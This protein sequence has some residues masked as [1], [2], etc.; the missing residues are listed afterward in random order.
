M[1][2]TDSEGEPKGSHRLPR[3]AADIH[4]AFDRGTLSRHLA[5]FYRD[6]ETQL[7]TAA[8]YIAVGLR[9]GHRCLYLVD[10]TTRDCIERALRTVGVDVDARLECGDLLIAEAEEVYLDSG[11][12]PERMIATLREACTESVTDGYE[13]L[14][15]AGENTW[16]FHTD[17]TFD[18]VVDFEAQFDA[19]CPDLP[20]TA[21]CQYDLSRFSEQSAA[22]AL[23][24][25]EQII[26][27]DTVCDNPYYVPPE[28]YRSESES[29]MNV[30]LMLE[31]TYRLART[32]RQVDR[33]EERLS[34]VSRILRHN[35]RN[36]LNVAAGILETLREDEG[37]PE[38]SR[39]QLEAAEESLGN[40]VEKAEKT[41]YVQRTIRNARR[42]TVDLASV[43]ARAV[44]RVER[45]HPAATIT[46]SGATDVLVLGVEN[47]E[48][49]L[50]EV[51]S[52]GI[53]HQSGESPAVTVTV[54]TPSP[55]TVALDVRSPG[56][57]IP[58]IETQAL[59]RG[60][61]TP[62]EHGS[63][64]GLWLVK[65]LVEN[66]YG[67]LSFPE[68]ENSRVRIDLHRVSRSGDRK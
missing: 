40:V 17:A 61:E 41:R 22:K 2:R 30:R 6:P 57:P 51:L 55:D 13:G 39:E 50:E 52:N 58:E 37:L 59:L 25:H 5:L 8:T 49:A 3:I 21:L 38:T 19:C 66:A 32:R 15:A 42:E 16:C 60:S 47:L 29:R 34:V 45:D 4:T 23:W 9:T 44:D 65:W 36:D 24:T 28:E 12:D 7:E 35:I 20:V 53:R 18:H 68:S 56:P 62:L 14:W 27:R 10:D 31:Q 67:T 11:F 46:V 48:V 63:G 33:R 64:L 1:S 26:Y 43:L 54:S